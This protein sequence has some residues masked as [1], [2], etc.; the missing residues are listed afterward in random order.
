MAALLA[1]AA[2]ALGEDAR[3]PLPLPLLD[4]RELELAEPAAPLLVPSGVVVPVAPS[5]LLAVTEQEMGTET[6]K[7]CDE[8]ESVETEVG[9]P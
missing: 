2:S 3:L 5:A 7:G 8:H 1:V 6:R 9:V 4:G